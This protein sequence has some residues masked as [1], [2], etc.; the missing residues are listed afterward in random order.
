MA[1]EAQ[2]VAE[3]ARAKYEASLET[4]RTFIAEYPAISRRVDEHD[5]R[6]NVLESRFADLRREISDVIAETTRVSK[7]SSLDTPT[8]SIPLHVHRL[9]EFRKRDS[10]HATN[11]AISEATAPVSERPQSR[12]SFAEAGTEAVWRYSFQEHEAIFPVHGHWLPPHV[13]ANRASFQEAHQFA[14]QLGGRLV[15]LLPEG[16]ED[17]E[18]VDCVLVEPMGKILSPSEYVSTGLIV[19]LDGAAHESELLEEWGEVLKATKWLD[20]GISFALPDVSNLA[21]AEDL[22]RV[23]EAVIKQGGFQTCILTG[24][25]WGAQLASE[26]AARPRLSERVD[27][28]VLVAPESPVPQ[29]CRQIEMP[30]MLIWANNDEVSPFNEIRAWYEVLGERRAPTFVKDLEDGGHDL[31]KLLKQGDTASQVLLFTVSC[32]LMGSLMITMDEAGNSDTLQLSESCARLC[33]E[34]PC[35][36]AGHVGGDPEKGVAAAISGDASRV[37]R[38]MQRLASSLREWIQEGLQERA[39]ATE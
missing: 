16:I 37:K 17:V 13:T 9:G 22:E 25:G 8:D 30:V 1:F 38:R 34:L 11:A 29:E 24:K 20:S 27:G 39:S 2:K 31:A 12:V 4:L 35:F 7:R 18:S 5:G 23:V 3:E 21:A 26:I 36:L 19:C 32:L 28:V 10:T 14:K 33:D 15:K 6:L